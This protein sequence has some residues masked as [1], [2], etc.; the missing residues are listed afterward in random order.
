MSLYQDNNGYLWAGTYTGLSILGGNNEHVIYSDRAEVRSLAGSMVLDIQGTKDGVHWIRSNMGVYRWDME[1]HSFRRFSEFY[2][3]CRMA[4]SPMGDVVVMSP[5]TGCFFYNKGEE[6]FRPL[7]VEHI[8]L[9]DLLFMGVD[10]TLTLTLMTRKELVHYTLEKEKSGMLTAHQSDRE[11]WRDDEL[12]FVQSLEGQLIMVMDSQQVIGSN[13]DGSKRKKLFQM[14]SDVRRHRAVSGVAR[15]DKDYLVGFYQDGVFRFSK[16]EDGNWEEYP[17]DINCGIIAMKPDRRQDIVWVASDGKG[18]MCITHGKF[19]CQNLPFSE[20]PIEMASPVRA[21]IRIENGDLLVG[22]KGDGLLRYAGFEPFSKDWDRSK[23]SRFTSRNSELLDNSVYCLAPSTHGIVWIGTDGAGLNYYNPTDGSV[24]KL[25]VGISLCQH[26]HAIK[27]IDGT[28]LYA[29]ANLGEGI[30]RLHLEWDGNRPRVKK[31]DRPMYV[32]DLRQQPRFSSVRRSGEYLWLASRENGIVRLHMPTGKHQLFRFA[33]EKQEVENDAICLDV[34]NENT[35]F[36][37][38]SAG[39]FELQPTSLTRDTVVSPVNIVEQVSP[40]DMCIRGVLSTGKNQLWLS[41]SHSIFSYDTQTHE[42]HALAGLCV[43]EFGDGACYWDRISDGKF[44]GGTQGLVV[45]REVMRERV[46]AKQEETEMMPPILF[47]DTQVGNEYAP[48]SI[49]AQG[50]SVC[51]LHHEQ[52]F[53]TVSYSAIDYLNGE[54]YFFSYRIG[55]QDEWTSNGHSRNITFSSMPPGRYNLQVRYQRGNFISVPYEMVIYIAHPWYTTLWAKMLWCLLG[56]TLVLMFALRQ[57]QRQRRKQFYAMEKLEQEHELQNYE[58]KL[59]FFTNI[60]HEFGAPLMLISEPCQRIMNSDASPTIKRYASI[61]QHS[62]ERMGSLIQQL[63]EFRRIQTGNREFKATEENVSQMLSQLLEQFELQ[64]EER[65]ITLTG[66][67]ENNIIW[68][69]DKNALTSIFINLLSNALKYVPDNGRVIVKLQP[70]DEHIELSVANNGQMIHPDELNRLFDRYVVLD[71]LEEDNRHRK[72]RNG[73]GLAIAKGLA[74]GMGGSISVASDEQLTTFSVVLPRME[75]TPAKHTSTAILAAYEPSVETLPQIELP[76]TP[77]RGDDN[78]PTLFVIDDDREILW[79]LSDVLKTEYNVYPF[80]NG[81]QALE[82]M[83]KIRPQLII[84][85]VFMEGMSGIEVCRHVK[86]DSNLAHIPFIMLSSSQDEQTQVDS[87]HAGADV[88][89]S[90]PFNVAYVKSVVASLVN[91]NT[92]LKSYF[93]SASSAFEMSDGKVLHR[94]DKELIDKVIAIIEENIVNPDLTPAL[95]AEKMNMGLRNLYRKIKPISDKPLT[96]IIRDIR[97]EHTRQLLV[98]TRLSMEE[99]C[100]KSGFSNR[101][102]F[103]KQFAAKFG[104]T[105]RQYH[106]QMMEEA[107]KSERA[108]MLQLQAKSE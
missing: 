50:R 98:H 102:T 1:N 22:T 24:H 54:D 88:Y 49:D 103:Y 107:L 33:P 94:E 81:A 3:N 9:D 106:E 47:H 2:G 59:R 51:H 108:T 63:I 10:S 64:A 96:T 45:A 34:T 62:A 66:K 78:A 67:I 36:C 42:Y 30:F 70:R 16:S 17:T 87:V 68:P 74:E 14:P 19:Q 58:S 86:A 8:D 32:K 4:V 55:N 25:D 95:I 72:K 40:A 57:I 104:C 15:W 97:L 75:V 69:T 39:L 31:V 85:D 41:T 12:T 21:I 105:P 90:K 84:C 53:F 29:C 48:T 61:I 35:I 91:R 79:L 38:T 5:Q 82:E 26:I 52:N 7:A 83:A 56:A 46:N 37:G 28:D 6:R 89:L 73:L 20:L 92:R 60:T 13:L 44:F 80:T 71:R 76:L 101:G 100:F 27:E 99:I 18:L 65:D 11:L 23:V 43:M 77:H 93:E